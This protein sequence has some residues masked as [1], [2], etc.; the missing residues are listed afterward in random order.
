VCARAAAVCTAWLARE[1]KEREKKLEEAQEE[2]EKTRDRAKKEAQWLRATEAKD[3]VRGALADLWDKKRVDLLGSS[4]A[5]L[6]DALTEAKTE[7]QRVPSVL[8]P[9][10]TNPWHIALLTL[11]ALLVPVVALL[12]DAASQPPLV[13]VLGGLASLIPVASTALRAATSWTRKQVAD[14]EAAEDRIKKQVQG[15]VRKA[16]Q[17]VADAQRALNDVRNEMAKAQAEAEAAR[18]RA[19]T[20]QERITELTPGRVFVDFADE[21]STTT[22]AVS[23]CCPPSVRT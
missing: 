9:F 15:T 18:A 12:L 23:A 11:G 14:L 2:A 7:V 10:W 5:E 22:A 13:S 16:D 21:P 19:M 8:G 4:G 6:L 1:A 3:S 17:K 20:L